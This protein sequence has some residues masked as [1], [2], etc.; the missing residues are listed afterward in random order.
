MVKA[1]YRQLQSYVNVE[2]IQT[3]VPSI[4]LDHLSFGAAFPSAHS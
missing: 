4:A 1:A 3:H 2:E